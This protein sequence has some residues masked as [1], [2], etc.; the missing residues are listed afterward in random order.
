MEKSNLEKY[1]LDY[2]ISL[3]KELI[4]ENML[5]L[6]EKIDYHFKDI[7]L[8]A[9]AMGVIKIEITC[10]TCSPARRIP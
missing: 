4:K 3:C 8:L 7:S 9:R 6:E 10:S 2:K 1:I 5:E